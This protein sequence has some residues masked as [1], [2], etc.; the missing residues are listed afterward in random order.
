MNDI[1]LIIEEIRKKVRS[2]IWIKNLSKHVYLDNIYNVSRIL[3]NNTHSPFGLIIIQDGN[4][5][6][7]AS[8][9]ENGDFNKPLGDPNFSIDDVVNFIHQIVEKH[10]KLDDIPVVGITWT[11]SPA[12]LKRTHRHNNQIPFQINLP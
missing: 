6:F 12:Q 3:K 1:E 5:L 2:D 9:G 11:S 4:F 10:E 7:S 8:F